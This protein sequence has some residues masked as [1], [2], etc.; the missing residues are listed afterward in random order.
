MASVCL[1][2]HQ[3]F[4]SHSEVGKMLKTAKLMLFSTVGHLGWMNASNFQ[5]ILNNLIFAIWTWQTVI[6][7]MLRSCTHS[8]F[9]KNGRAKKMPIDLISR[10]FFLRSSAKLLHRLHKH[11]FFSIVRWCDAS[12]I[13]SLILFSTFFSKIALELTS[14]SIWLY[15]N[16]QSQMIP[17]AG[18]RDSCA[19]FVIDVNSR[20]HQYDGCDDK[21]TCFLPPFATAPSKHGTRKHRFGWEFWYAFVRCVPFR[22]SNFWQ[23]T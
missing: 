1:L 6:T 18:K 23:I 11:L 15:L 8:S 20:P 10:S 17:N 4:R 13:L 14:K 9:A 22:V 19:H 7:E 12:F 16:L 21:N 2:S 3:W 5:C